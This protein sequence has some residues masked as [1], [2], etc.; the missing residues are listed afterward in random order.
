MK[1]SLLLATSM[2]GL[3]LILLSD[4]DLMCILVCIIVML[5]GWGSVFLWRINDCV[6]SFV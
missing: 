4:V 5:S 2:Y 6:S 3:I 1:N